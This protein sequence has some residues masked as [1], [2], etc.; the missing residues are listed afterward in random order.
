MSI[1]RIPLPAESSDRLPRAIELASEA[2]G[3][4]GRSLLAAGDPRR[5]VPRAAE[6]SVHATPGAVLIRMR[7]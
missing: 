7:G 6:P 1:S 4:S 5:I 2:A 3:A